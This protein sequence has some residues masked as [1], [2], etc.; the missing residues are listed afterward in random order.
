M[1]PDLPPDMQTLAV[2]YNRALASFHVLG[3]THPD[4]LAAVAAALELDK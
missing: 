3:G 4:A 1:G 2:A